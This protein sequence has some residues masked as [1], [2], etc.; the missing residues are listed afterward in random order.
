MARRGIFTSSILPDATALGAS[1]GHFIRDQSSRIA[2]HFLTP[3]TDDIGGS[4]DWIYR[5]DERRF[6]HGISDLL[7]EETEK[8]GMMMREAGKLAWEVGGK[9]AMQP[10]EPSLSAVTPTLLH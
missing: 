4:P 7:S 5:S 9:G 10:L 2:S 3:H 1:G 6:S 8:E